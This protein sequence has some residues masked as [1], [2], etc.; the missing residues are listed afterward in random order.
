MESEIKSGLTIDPSE[1]VEMNEG[2]TWYEVYKDPSSGKA[3]RALAEN[4]INDRIAHYYSL[5]SILRAYMDVRGVPYKKP[6]EY[7]L[8]YESERIFDL[9][10]QKNRAQQQK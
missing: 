10:W 9:L 7:T 8:K 5:F 1:G 4:L 2:K 6:H 3:T